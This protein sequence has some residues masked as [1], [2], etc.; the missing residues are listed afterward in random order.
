MT[1]VLNKTVSKQNL[2]GAGPLCGTQ[3][4]LSRVGN[5]VSMGSLGRGGERAIGNVKD[6]SQESL[7]HPRG[8]CV[9]FHLL[10][11]SAALHVPSSWQPQPSSDRC[12][13]CAVLHVHS[14]DSSNEL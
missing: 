5:G 6:K 8:L 1:D 13:S 3:I 14:H 7:S 9:R 12:D 2:N 11:D 4:G 10:R